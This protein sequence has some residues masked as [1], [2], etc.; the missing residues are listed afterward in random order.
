MRSR[1]AAATA[2]LALATAGTATAAN[3]HYTGD[4][5]HS[6]AVIALD[7]V[8][9]KGKPKQ[10]DAVA[11]DDVPVNCSNTGEGTIG[12]GEYNF[13]AA[14]VKHR[15]FQAHDGSTT[16]HNSFSVSGRFSRDGRQ[17]SGQFQYTYESS[18]QQCA[19]P[20]L[21]WSAKR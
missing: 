20:I 4:F 10:V 17:A 19:T 21:A 6:D 13:L 9:Q 5:K 16:L 14:P 7:V 15:A 11:Y 2:L 1:I 12:P 8:V 3:R 18:G